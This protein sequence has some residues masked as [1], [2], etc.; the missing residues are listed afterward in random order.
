MS[1]WNLLMMIE[2]DE[3]NDAFPWIKGKSFSSREEVEFALI[4]AERFLKTCGFKVNFH[5]NE[6]TSDA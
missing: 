6:V 5:L 1:K 2:Y 4:S 3:K